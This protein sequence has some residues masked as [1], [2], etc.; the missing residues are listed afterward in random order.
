VNLADALDLPDV[1]AVTGG[2]S[3]AGTRTVAAGG[4]AAVPTGSR[5]RIASLTKT[6]TATALVLTL[7]EQ[8]VALSTPA[9]ELLPHLAD[10]WR[11]DPG[12][13]IEQLLGQVSGL[14]ESVSASDVAALGDGPGALDE[15]ARLVV[16]AGND[17]PP[18]A[19]WSYY[20]GN[21]FLAGAM[22]AARN[23]MPYEPALQ[24]TLL[25]PGGCPA[26][27]ST[28]RMTRSPAGTVPPRSR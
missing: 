9:I 2:V 11:A 26:P 24:R 3:V 12:L 25:E 5:F 17:R 6:F 10:D 8:D 18:G 16:R 28:H 1:P 22:L 20:N 15:T 7:R 19:Q 27:A 21:Y 14:R 13:T 4:T 23:D